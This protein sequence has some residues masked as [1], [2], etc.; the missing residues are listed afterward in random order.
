MIDRL[1]EQ[2][3][4]SDSNMQCVKNWAEDRAGTQPNRGG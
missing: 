4:A 3:Q 2:D 1:F